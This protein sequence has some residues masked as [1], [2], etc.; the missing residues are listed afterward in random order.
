LNLRGHENLNGLPCPRTSRVEVPAL[1]GKSQPARERNGGS[2]YGSDFQCG[3][4]AIRI[5]GTR[6]QV[7][8][9]SVRVVQLQV[10]VRVPH[11]SVWVVQLQVFVRVPHSSV[12]V[13]QL[14]VFVRVPHSSVWVVQLQVFVRVPQRHNPHRCEPTL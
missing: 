9:S 8:H 5:N 11:S 13:V 3:Q 14:Q 12:W 1:L 2:Q 6:L 4:R 7:L 10:F